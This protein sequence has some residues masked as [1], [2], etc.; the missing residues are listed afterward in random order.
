MTSKSHSPAPPHGPPSP[1][2]WVQR[3]TAYLPAGSR[4]LDLA[5]GGGRHSRWLLAQ[6]MQV[7][8]LDRDVAALRDIEDRIEVVESDLE[9]G[10]PF[11][12]AGRHFA[13]VIVT[14]YLYRPLLP[15]IVEALD[16]QGVLLY[17]T[18]SV[19]NARFGR[20]SN[21][22]FLLRPGELL[23]LAR[24]RLRVL[25]YEDLIVDTPKAAAVQ[26]ICA[27]RDTTD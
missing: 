4:V 2:P 21:P 10:R 27:I 5:S 9:D 19:D 11:A 14:N 16:P 18:F 7:T 13:G 25:A 23:E 24:G 8:A 3:F 20:P 22:E 26:R 12:L 1:S 6:G 17:E 15:A